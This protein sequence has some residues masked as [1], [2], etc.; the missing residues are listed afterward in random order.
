MSAEQTFLGPL[1]ASRRDSS[2][3]LTGNP[4]ATVGCTEKTAVAKEERGPSLWHLADVEARAFGA[5]DD[6]RK[7]CRF[8][9]KMAIFLSLTVYERRTHPSGQ[10]VCLLSLRRTRFCTTV[11]GAVVLIL[12]AAVISPYAGVAL[13]AAI[14]VLLAPG[15]VRAGRALGAE[16]RLRRLS[17]PGPHVYL[18]SLASTSPGAGADLLR[19]LALEADNK[20]WSLLLDASNERLSKYYENFGFLSLGPAVQMP[21][22]S[23]HRR[24]WR[25]AP[26]VG[27]GRCERGTQDAC[28]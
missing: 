3:K 8:R 6:D 27:N 24:M 5:K 7:V 26:A 19:Q 2:K 28:Q 22:G 25:P 15:A 12:A 14:I 9:S 10:A 13:A 18:H 20:R 1:E 11:A 23:S 17:P 16:S 4:T 21:D